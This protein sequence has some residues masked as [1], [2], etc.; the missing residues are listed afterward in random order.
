MPTRS[1]RPRAG[2]RRRRTADP[3]HLARRP[4]GRPPQRRGTGDRRPA[5][6]D[7]RCPPTP[8]SASSTASRHSELRQEYAELVNLDLVEVD[9]VDDGETLA[10][11]ADGSQ[12]FIIA[13][14][15]LEHCEDP[16]GTIGTHLRKLQAGRRPLLH[17]PD[18]RYTFDSGGR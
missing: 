13:N 15:F 7:P 17:G 14:H 1:H 16:I 10:T 2:G 3:V 18:K 12:A 4:R 11:I 5:L 8:R 6:T 9:I